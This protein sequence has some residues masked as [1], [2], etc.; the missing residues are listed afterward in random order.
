MGSG[1]NLP[2]VHVNTY[3]KAVKT[4]DQTHQHRLKRNCC[5][6]AIV[7]HCERGTKCAK[8]GKSERHQEIGLL[9]CHHKISLLNTLYLVNVL[10]WFFLCHG[11]PKE[12]PTH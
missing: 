11:G 5:E 6:V 3:K 9:N 7:H 1:F 12:A 8:G 4:I 10:P 2:P